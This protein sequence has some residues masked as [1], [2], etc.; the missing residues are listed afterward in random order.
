M[1]EFEIDRRKN[2]H[3]LRNDPLLK[4]VF[5]NGVKDFQVIYRRGG[6]NIKEWIATPKLNSM[7][8]KDEEVKVGCYECGKSCIDCQYLKEKGSYFVSNITKR[9]HKV[10]Q[11]VNCLSKNVVYLVT[12]KKCGKQGVGE[13]KNFKSRMA[14]YRSSIRNKKVA[15]NIDKHFIESAEHSLDDFDAQI[16][17]QIEKPPRDKKMLNKRLK[18][19]EG[20]WQIQLC[21]LQPYGLNSINELEC[22]LK[23][24]DKNIFYP[25]QDKDT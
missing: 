13:T 23:F 2:E 3:I 25:T 7:D 1:P 12:C 16:I 15:C 6:K 18:Q 5:P 17:C 19:F 20:Y 21:T 9:R 14:N 11:Y 22:N 24:C 4:N 10:R 8:S